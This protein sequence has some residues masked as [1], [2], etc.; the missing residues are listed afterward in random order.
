MAKLSHFLREHTPYCM[1]DAMLT[2][3]FGHILD[4]PIKETLQMWW[5]HR[6]TGAASLVSLYPSRLTWAANQIHGLANQVA[7]WFPPGLCLSR[8][9][10]A[11]GKKGQQSSLSH[12][13]WLIVCVTEILVP[14]TVGDSRR[15]KSAMTHL[16]A[17]SHID[18]P[19]IY[20]ARRPNDSRRNVFR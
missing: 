9:W 8:D 6:H 20:Q 7:G 17:L 10:V 2:L 15:V 4:Q 5:R 12:V 19:G 18:E 11:A 1:P 14:D 16:A 3:R 13:R